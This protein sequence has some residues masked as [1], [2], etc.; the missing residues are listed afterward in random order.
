MVTS[1]RLGGEENFS[2]LKTA[3]TQFKNE[4]QA[5]FKQ[6]GGVPSQVSVPTEARKAWLRQPAA[7]GASGLRDSALRVTT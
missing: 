4:T 2:S 6:L 1:M 7:T 3:I 5:G